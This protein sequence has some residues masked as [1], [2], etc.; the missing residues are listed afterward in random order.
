MQGKGA[1]SGKVYQLDG[2]TTVTG[3]MQVYFC[4]EG[5][6][7]YFPERYDCKECGKRML[8]NRI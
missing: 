3:T 5:V 6:T 4:V 7:F 8:G 2:V 1:I